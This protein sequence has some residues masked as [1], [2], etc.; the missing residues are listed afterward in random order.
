MS[1]QESTAAIIAILDDF[2]RSAMVM[3]LE[4]AVA[5]SVF[6][7]WYDEAAVYRFGAGSSL[8]DDD[9]NGWAERLKL[10]RLGEALI[11]ASKAVS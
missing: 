3:G 9:F 8:S 5:L 2:V 11:R 4:K 7:S 6:S 10:R 1:P